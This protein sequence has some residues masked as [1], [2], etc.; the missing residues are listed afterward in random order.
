MKG[1]IT[2]MHIMLTV[3]IIIG[4]VCRALEVVFNVDFIAAAI[5]WS[6]LVHIFRILS[7][8]MDLVQ[9][10]TLLI[11]YVII[12]VKDT[13]NVKQWRAMVDVARVDCM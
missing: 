2:K 1:R 6:Y 12:P 4:A 13:M 9:S 10:T 7:F 3:F 11:F 8:I 5:Q